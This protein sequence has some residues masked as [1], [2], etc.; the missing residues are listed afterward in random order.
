LNLAITTNLPNPQP[1]VWVFGG[2]LVSDPDLDLGYP[3]LDPGYPYP[4]THMGTQT[5]DVHYLETWDDEFENYGEGILGGIE[6]WGWLKDKSDSEYDPEDSPESE[7]ESEVG[8]EDFDEEGEIRKE[9]ELLAFSE[10][11]R[12]AQVDAVVL[13]KAQT[14]KSSD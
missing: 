12:Q 9:A 2:C 1:W 10:A 14:T 13:E 7:T 6:S 8:L 4:G 3:Y 11:L 5:H